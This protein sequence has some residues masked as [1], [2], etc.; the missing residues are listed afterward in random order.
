MSAIACPPA[1]TQAKLQKAQ[2]PMAE[3]PL[4]EESNKDL[5]PGCSEGMP[6]GKRTVQFDPNIRFLVSKVSRI[7][8]R[9]FNLMDIM[10]LA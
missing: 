1:I 4:L 6:R 3:S 2:S 10:S 5:L 7:D 9:L 8:E